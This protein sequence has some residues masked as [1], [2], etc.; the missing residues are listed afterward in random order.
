MTDAL[1][2]TWAAWTTRLGADLDALA[3]DDWMTFTVHVASQATQA[4]GAYAGTRAPRGWRRSG[5]R[6]RARSGARS[7]ARTRVPDVLVQ[8]R[9][10]EGV[11]A[12]ECIGDTEF[13]GLTDLT[14]DEQ[15]ALSG[16]GWER[17]GREPEF[18]RTFTDGAAAARLVQASLTEEIGADTP[19]DVDV[20]RAPRPREPP[21]RSAR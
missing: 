2:E 8:A 9:R 4:S 7:G 3:G 14:H 21:R 11:I 6:S 13:E 19:A 17:E 5:A 12:L 16:L 10:L 20:R 1:E 18:S 15:S